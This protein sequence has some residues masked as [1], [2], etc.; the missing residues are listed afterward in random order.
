MEVQ[1]HRKNEGGSA[2]AVEGEESQ[3]NRIEEQVVQN[4]TPREA[5][6]VPPPVRM[7]TLFGH[8]DAYDELSEQWSTYVERFEHFIEA[9]A[10]PAT[11]KEAVFLSVIGATTYGLLRSL[12]APD[13]PSSKTYKDL[14]DTLD[15]HFSPKP[16]VIAE[17][18]K[19]HKRNQEEGET[20]AQYVAVLKKLSEHC[21]FGAHLLDA[22]R[23]RLVCGLNNEAI[24]RKLLTEEK[25]DFK[26]AVEVALAM[27][28]VAR[29]S[30]QW[31]VFTTGWR[32]MFSL[33][34]D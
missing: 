15:G 7:A 13:K 2:L 25:L 31:R 27:E 28:T 3:E 8:I 33:W 9:N 12:L 26:K 17:R 30:L 16:I 34:Q 23:D 18:F 11:K 6:A 24:Q 5:L 32:Q 14:V 1:R 19:F 21:D 4:K 10:V 22:L 20:I 29:E